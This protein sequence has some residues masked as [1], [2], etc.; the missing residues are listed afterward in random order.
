[1]GALVVAV[2]VAKGLLVVAVLVVCCK[3]HLI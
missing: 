2:L 1:V 3:A